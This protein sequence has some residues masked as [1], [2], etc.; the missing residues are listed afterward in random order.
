MRNHN[1]TLFVEDFG[2]ETFLDAL[3]RRFAEQYGVL[4]EIEYASSTGGHGRLITV[5]NPLLMQ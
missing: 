1:I 5:W 2:H 4:I 3:L